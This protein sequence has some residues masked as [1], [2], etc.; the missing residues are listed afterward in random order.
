MLEMRNRAAAN[1]WPL[2]LVMLLVAAMGGCAGGPH[3]QGERQLT[4]TAFFANP[5]DTDGRGDSAGATVGYNHFLRDRLALMGA[6]TPYRNHNQGD[7]DAYAAEFQIGLRWY[8]WEFGDELQPAALFSEGL[9]G[10]IYSSSSIPEEGTN[11]NLTWEIGL[12][13]EVPLADHICWVTGCRLRHLSHGHIFDG[14]NPGEDDQ[15]VY[16]GLAFS[17]G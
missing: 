5:F 6:L 12:G 3:R 13:V 16:M 9:V 4:M 2:P 8:F 10:M 1:R 7:G 14:K 15:Q 17:I 11:T